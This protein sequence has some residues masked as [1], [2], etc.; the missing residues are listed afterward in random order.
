MVTALPAAVRARPVVL[1][2]D[3]ECSSVQQQL[4]ALDQAAP[5]IFTP[6]HHLHIQ[7]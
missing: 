3:V 7:K 5:G 2:G 6:D 4:P 1:A